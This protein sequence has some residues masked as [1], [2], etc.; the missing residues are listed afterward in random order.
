MP[1]GFYSGTDSC[2]LPRTD[3]GQIARNGI[4]KP[5]EWNECEMQQQSSYI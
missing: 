5:A 3:N 4:L 2:T 1:C